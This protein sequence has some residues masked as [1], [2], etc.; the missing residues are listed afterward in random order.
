MYWRASWKRFENATTLLRGS[1]SSP[2]LL[3]RGRRVKRRRSVCV[4]STESVTSGYPAQD[5]PNFMHLIHSGFSSPHFTLLCLIEVSDLSS[6]WHQISIFDLEIFLL[7]R[8]TAS[9]GSWLL[10]S[11]APRVWPRHRV[12]LCQMWAKS[13]NQCYVISQVRSCTGWPQQRDSISPRFG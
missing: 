8:Q 10:Q 7:A 13:G 1:F 5:I 9:F 2:I 12:L 6:A 4:S 11:F 3:G